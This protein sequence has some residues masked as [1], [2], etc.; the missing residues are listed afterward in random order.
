M[1]LE[2]PVFPY[3]LWGLWEGNLS[4]PLQIHDRSDLSFLLTQHYEKRYEARAF[5]ERMDNTLRY[6]QITS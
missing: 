3:C 5:S 1:S 6:C 2:D 4:Y